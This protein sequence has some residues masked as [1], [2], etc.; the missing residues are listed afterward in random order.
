LLL[1]KKADFSKILIDEETILPGM[2]E[3]PADSVH[4]SGAGRVHLFQGQPTL[5]PNGPYAS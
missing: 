4:G 3:K 1:K 5:I 2:T